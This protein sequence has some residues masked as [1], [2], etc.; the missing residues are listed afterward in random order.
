MSADSWAICPQC[1]DKHLLSIE[2]YA[3]RV[4]SAYGSVSPEEFIKLVADLEEMK[5]EE[6]ECTLREVYS[7]GIV[8][9]EY[10]SRYFAGCSA[11]G[12][13]YSKRINEKVYP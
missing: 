12:W 2:G 5:N 3:G 10:C 4:N 11:C 9:D 8:D 13:K 1:H 7:R 6:E